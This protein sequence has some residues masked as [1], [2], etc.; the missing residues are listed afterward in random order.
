MKTEAIV[1]LTGDVKKTDLRSVWLAAQNHEVLRE[2]FIEFSPFDQTVKLFSNVEMDEAAGQ[3]TITLENKTRSPQDA[4]QLLVAG[5]ESA[6]GEAR[7]VDYGAFSRGANPSGDI[8]FE[9]RL[10]G[11]KLRF[12]EPQTP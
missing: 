8:L 5:F 7:F 12:I 1:E 3:L 6:F 4:K 9:R 11:F 2:R 10:V